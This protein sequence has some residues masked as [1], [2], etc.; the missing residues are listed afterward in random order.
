MKIRITVLVLALVLLTG[1]CSTD[2]IPEPH[3]S[4]EYTLSG[5]VLDEITNAPISGA[6]VFI[7]EKEGGILVQTPDKQIAFTKTDGN[8]YYEIKFPVQA[9][10]YLYMFQARAQHKN[11][12]T[13]PNPERVTIAKSGKSTFD[14]KLEPPTWVKISANKISNATYMNFQGNRISGT[15]H[16]DNLDSTYQFMVGAGEPL[17]ITLFSYFNNP[18]SSSNSNQN[19]GM[20]I[21]FDTAEVTLKY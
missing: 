5:Y 2:S 12:F 15:F 19:F 11:Y 17:D 6:E 1:S 4:G 13:K 10:G 3:Y 9:A 21:P 14:W 16:N 7:L 18:D 20:L 8:G